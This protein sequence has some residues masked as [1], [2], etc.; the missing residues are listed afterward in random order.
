MLLI[1]L[2]NYDGSRPLESYLFSIYAYKLTD[3][4]REGRRPSIQMHGFSSTAGEIEPAG[5]DRGKF[6]R[7]ERGTQSIEEM[8]VKDAIAEQIAR[9]KQNGSWVKL[10]AIE[11]LFVSG[12]SNKEVAEKLAISEQ[13]VANYKSD[14]QIRL[15]AIVQ[16][17]DLDQSVFPELA[18]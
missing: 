15:K 16:R 18:E 7:T 1:S 8:A 5:V 14:F 13:Q 4:L 9:W 6:H 3:N 12:R 10:Q 11:L 2:P 17:M